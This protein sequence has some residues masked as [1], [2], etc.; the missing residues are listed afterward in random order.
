[1]FVALGL[2]NAWRNRARTALGII[3]MAVAAVIFMSSSTLSKG[4][5]AGAF[6]EARQLIGGE[7]LML[8]ERIALSTDTLSAGG[9]TWRFER[10]SYDKPN[11][12]L[13]FDPTPYWYGGMVSSSAP[14][15]NLAEVAHELREDPSV[16]SVFERKSIPFLNETSDS[17]GPIYQYGFIEPRDVRSDIEVYRLDEALYWGRYLEPGNTMEG[18]AC[19]GWENLSVGGSNISIPVLNESGTFDYENSVRTRIEIVG[20]ASFDNPVPGNPPYA[21]PVVFVTP[22]TFRRIEEIAGHSEAW[23]FSISVRNMA[24]LESY[25]AL[26]RRRYPDF[27]IYTVSQLAAA[28]TTRER[29]A[30][31]VPMDMRRVTELLS[32][33]IAALLSATNLSVLMLARKTEIGIL[34]A[35][36]ATAWNIS[37]MVLAESVWIAL[38]GSIVG[39]AI[40]QP[41]ILW[42]LLSNSIDSGVVATTILANLGKAVGFS[43]AAAILFGFLPISKA[44]RVTPAQVLRGE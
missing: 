4:Y 40:T 32:F 35:L 42:Q 2:K 26:L 36:G 15:E 21:N 12:V 27:T 38:L 24:D 37:S 44:L 41:A 20:R 5:P 22:D 11:L 28:A 9:H 29:V 25:A 19:S 18:V 33:M 1:M 17:R 10:R 31:G 23:G 30:A 3:S 43:V 8:P 34:R 6:W 39:G 14:A 7:I 13:G 16:L